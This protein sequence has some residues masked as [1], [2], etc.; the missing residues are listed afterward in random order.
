MASC[1]ESKSDKAGSFV[2]G[3]G[4]HFIYGQYQIGH[5]DGDTCGF[6]PFFD[7]ACFGL[8]VCISRQNGV[9]D[10]HVEIK[11]DT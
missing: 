3:S 8:F 11:C 4:F 9:G 2:F 7:H 10:R 5:F 6:G 1:A